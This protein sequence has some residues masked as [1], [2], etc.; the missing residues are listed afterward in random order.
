[1]EA[2]IAGAA[3]VLIGFASGQ[4]LSLAFGRH[5]TGTLAQR[6]QQLEAQHTELITRKE[7]ATAFAQVA[8]MEAQR[9][10]Q[11]QA[12]ARAESVFGVRP[13]TPADMNAAINAQLAALG[14]RMNQMNAQLGLGG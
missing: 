2:F 3:S 6:I 14:D 5:R 8:Q 4:G 13:S 10:Q 7:V 11:Q 9:V 1:M 12:A